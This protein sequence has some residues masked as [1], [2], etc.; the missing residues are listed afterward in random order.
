M[1]IP[2]HTT[3]W[4]QGRMSVAKLNLVREWAS[5]WNNFT[6]SLQRAHIRINPFEDELIWNRN[7]AEGN[8]TAKL[9]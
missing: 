4:F 5:K 9:G 2:N 3:I 8:Y 7:M 6:D 1:T